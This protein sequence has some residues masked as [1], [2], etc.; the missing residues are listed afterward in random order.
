MLRIQQRLLSF[1]IVSHKIAHNGRDYKQDPTL[2]FVN[3]QLINLVSCC[4]T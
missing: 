2:N 3:F 4:W 1:S